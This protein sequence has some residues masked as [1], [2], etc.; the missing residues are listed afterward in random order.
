MTQVF[1]TPDHPLDLG[2]TYRHSKIG[3]DTIF[4]AGWSRIPNDYFSMRQA[5]RVYAPNTCT[6]P[7]MNSTWSAHMRTNHTTK[8]QMMYRCN[9]TEARS[10]TSSHV[11]HNAYPALPYIS[12]TSSP[13]SHRLSV[14]FSSRRSSIPRSRSKRPKTLCKPSQQT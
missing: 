13:H 6:H 10:R 12:H 8:V 4:T 2:M 1:I 3:P 9:T 5:R 14:I 7:R 11:A